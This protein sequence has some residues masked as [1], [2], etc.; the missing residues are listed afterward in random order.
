[1][2]TM[3]WCALECGRNSP[4][5]AG[6]SL[7][8]Y[9]SGDASRGRFGSELSGLC[10]LDHGFLLPSCRHFRAII[11][12]SQVNT[13]L[14]LGDVAGVQLLEQCQDVVLDFPWPGIINL[15]RLWA[16]GLSLGSSEGFTRII[17]VCR[18]A[19]KR[20][21]SRAIGI[22]LVAAVTLL[23][24]RSAT[25]TLSACPFRYVTGLVSSGCGSLRAIIALAW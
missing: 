18:I 8:S 24:F 3:L 13:K 17:A 11:Y 12:A 23:E 2:P 21:S 10:D 15:C 22:T 5:D 4:A 9:R 1:M 16:G 25:S 14:Q 7:A 20:W 19:I 6:A